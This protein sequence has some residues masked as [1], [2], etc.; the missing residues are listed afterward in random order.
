MDLAR[1]V[2]DDHG[3]EALLSTESDVEHL[4]LEGNTLT[5]THTP[6]LLRLTHLTVLKLAFNRIDAP[7]CKT[8]AQMLANGNIPLRD[9][10]L[11]HNNFGDDGMMILADGVAR[12]SHLKLLSVAKCSIGDAGI[13]ALV[14]A[15]LDSHCEI[16]RLDLSRNRFGVEGLELLWQL[17]KSSPTLTTLILKSCGI[18]SADIRGLANVV[19]G[20]GSAVLTQLDLRGNPLGD[21]GVEH[22]AA[23]LSIAP[24]PR[25]SSIDLQSTGISDVCLSVWRDCLL[26][27]DVIV[28]LNLQQNSSLDDQNLPALQLLLKLL[29]KNRTI[30]ALRHEP[31]SSA[32]KNSSPAIASFLPGFVMGA[33]LTLTLTVAGLAFY[34]ILKGKLYKA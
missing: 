30:M 18:T 17:V 10:E 3:L 5:L 1:R 29:G 21:L 27:N 2:L 4:N 19:Q 22:L 34:V 32:N 7:G 11:D 26:E 23:A 25:L 9:L 24:N 28:N 6:T 33:S 14:T 31:S 8:L 16:E 13:V 20:N 12:N 15:I